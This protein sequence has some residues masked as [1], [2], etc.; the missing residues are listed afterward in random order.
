MRP[1]QSEGTDPGED[2]P[3]IP[4]KPDSGESDSFLAKLTIYGIKQRDLTIS[5]RGGRAVI[6]LGS[7][8]Q[9]LFSGSAEAILA[10]PP[11][12]GVKGYTFEVPASTLTGPHTGA[13]I[14]VS[15]ELGSMRIPAGILAG[16]EGL[17]GK[18]AGINI[19]I[20]DKS[21]LPEDIK[22]AIGDRPIVSLTL[23]LNGEQTGWNNPEAPMTVSIPYTPTVKEL[24]NSES[25]VIWYIDGS[26]RAVSV[27][28][29]RYDPGTGTVTFSTTHFSHY[30]IAYNPVYFNDVA[31][32]AWYNKAVSFIAARGITLGTGNGRYSPEA[33]LTR[34]D[35]L[36]LLMRAFGINANENPK[37]NFSDAG[38]TYYTGYLAEA[39]KLG[40]SAGVGN[41]MFAPNKAITRQEMCTLLYNALKVIKQLP[42]TNNSDVDGR[43]K[44]LSDFTDEEQIAPWAREAMTLLVEH[45]MINGADGKLKPT[46]ITTRA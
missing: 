10:I 29:G 38:D 27:P 25:I 15:T 22:A 36:V 40:I 42:E 32:D 3:V 20:P 2:D 26:G 45:G 16:M 9:E 1:T 33:A 34:G 46:E 31:A 7:L 12:P 37:D 39:K 23:T 8:A 5:L 43:S 19:D 44:S 6:S 21:K 4:N 11:I 18:T 30:A 17:A 14:T 41:N 28:N 24:R 13:A 35:F